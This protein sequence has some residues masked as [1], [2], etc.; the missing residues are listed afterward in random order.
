MYSAAAMPTIASSTRYTAHTQY[1]AS[2]A[3]RRW[4]STS[5]PGQLDHRDPEVADTGVDRER[6]ALE[7]LWV[8]GVD[9]GQRCGVVATAQPGQRGAHHI[10]PQ[11]QAGIGQQ[12]HGSDRRDQQHERGERCPVTAPEGRLM[13][14]V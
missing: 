11:R 5:R 10:W 14:S 12:H 1:G 8:E 6:R 13:P 2:V 4:R 7:A 9:V 3:C